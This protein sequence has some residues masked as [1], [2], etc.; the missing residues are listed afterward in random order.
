[1]LRC[2][3]LLAASLLAALSTASAQEARPFPAN[4][5]RGVLVVTDPPE[6]LMNGRTA[7]LSPGSRIRGSDNM[8]VMSGALVGSKLLVHYTIDTSGLV[9]NVW[10][11]NAA[12]A[13]RRPWPSTP[14]QAASWLFD[15]AAQTWT[16]P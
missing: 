9:H 8:Q 11:L 7:R 14:E 1:M 12:E 2:A 13:S 3:L 5:L 15:P 10:I 4:A 6:V 16:R